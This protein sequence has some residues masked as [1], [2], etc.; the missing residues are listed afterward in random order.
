MNTAYCG[1]F[2]LLNL[3]GYFFLWEGYWLFTARGCNY[4]FIY[5]VEGKLYTNNCKS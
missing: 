1:V 4:L 2:Q 3:L 5:S